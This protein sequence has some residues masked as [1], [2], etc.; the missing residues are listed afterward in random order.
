MR[1]RN[2][3]RNF[4]LHDVENSLSCTLN[5]MDGQILKRFGINLNVH[6]P[7]CL[8]KHIKLFS[9]VCDFYNYYFLPVR[10]CSWLFWFCQTLSLLLLLLLL[11]IGCNLSFLFSNCTHLLF[12]ICIFL[13][14]SFTLF[15]ICFM[16]VLPAI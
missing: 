6:F 12:I 2:E 13:L 14:Y 4:A 9:K 1:L 10:A 15:V 11:L 7:S 5:G 8:L 3:P 16:A